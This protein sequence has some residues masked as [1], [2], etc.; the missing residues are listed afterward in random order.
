MIS[1]IKEKLNAKIRVEEM[2]NYYQ[3]MIDK[4]KC[5]QVKENKIK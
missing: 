5:L 1:N 2:Q 3:Q 4:E